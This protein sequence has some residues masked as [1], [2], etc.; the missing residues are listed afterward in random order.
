[1][2]VSHLV[3]LILKI[4]GLLLLHNFHAPSALTDHLFDIFA[5]LLHRAF[6]F[7][8]KSLLEIVKIRLANYLSGEKQIRE[9]IEILMSEDLINNNHDSLRRLQNRPSFPDHPFTK[10]L[11]YDNDC[12]FL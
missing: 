7:L 3:L 12:G 1:L 6:I 9:V 8:L 10:C 5:L 2:V 11:K 4:L